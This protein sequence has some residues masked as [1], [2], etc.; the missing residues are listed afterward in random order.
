MSNRARYIVSW[1]HINRFF[2]SSGSLLVWRKYFGYDYRNHGVGGDRIEN[3]LWRIKHH[4][5]P[6]PCEVVV[7]HVGGNNIKPKSDGRYI[8][9]GIKKVAVSLIKKQKD[10][11]VFLTGILPGRGKELSIVKKVNNV[12]EDITRD[13]NNIFFLKPDFRDW[14]NAGGSLKKELYSLDMLHLN[15]DGYELFARYIQKISELSPKPLCRIE[16][17]IT[18]DTI[19]Y[20]MDEMPCVFWSTDS[21]PGVARGPWYP[22]PPPTQP[23]PHFNQGP[24]TPSGSQSVVVKSIGLPGTHI[25]TEL[26]ASVKVYGGVL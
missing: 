9:K 17:I 4:N 14:L 8:A 18:D 11:L 12:L 22:P 13:C 21:D 2:S 19:R 6:G 25:V 23:P 1:S 16:P 26:G 5:L 24:C 20:T 10:V 15:T 3:V 7:V